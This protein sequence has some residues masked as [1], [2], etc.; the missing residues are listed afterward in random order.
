MTQKHRF[1]NRYPLLALLFVSLPFVFNTANALDADENDPSEVFSA[2]AYGN[3]LSSSMLNEKEIEIP[4]KPVSRETEAQPM[5]VYEMQNSVLREIYDY[6]L[7]NEMRPPPITVSTPIEYTSTDVYLVTEVIVNFIEEL[8]TEIIGEPK[9]LVEE[10]EDKTT[11]EVF[12]ELFT[13]YKLMTLLNGKEKISPNE[14][15]AELNRAVEDFKYTLSTLSKRLPASDEMKKRLLITAIY[16]MHPDGSTLPDMITGKTPKDVLQTAFSVRSK[17]NDVRMK[18]NLS[19]VAIPSISEYESVAPID[20]FLQTQFII[21]ELNMLK[22]PMKISTSTNNAKPTSGKT[23][24][25]VFHE[26]KHLEYM[27]DRLLG[28]M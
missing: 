12:Q 15:Y 26:M 27:L 22:M 6:S 25:H 10:Y 20:V 7:S 4:A 16:G 21:A 28:T 11:P 1:L 19:A 14:V 9:F 13:L 23:P 24:S 2:L 3:Q 8:H 17:L 5:H 18:Y